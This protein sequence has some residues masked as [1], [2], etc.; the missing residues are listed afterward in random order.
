M[1]LAT[2]CL[3]ATVFCASCDSNDTHP[4]YKKTSEGMLYRFH[5]QNPNAAKPKLTDFMKLEMKCYLNDTLYYDWQEQTDDMYAQLVEPKFRGDL[6][7]AYAM[8]HVGDSASF[9]IKADS[10]ASLYYDQDPKALGLAADDYFRYE[11]KLLEIKTKEEFQ[12]GLLRV[13]E[14]MKADARASLSNYVEKENIAVEPS[15]TGVYVV[16]LEKGKGRCPEKGEKVELDFEAHLTDGTL[17]G[18]TYNSGEP[19]SFVLGDNY[20]IAGW[21]EVVS[22]MHLGD[23]VRAIIPFD[24]AYN[25]HSVG[26]IPPYAN[27]VYDIKLLKITTK[28]ELAR[29][30]EQELKKLKAE[31]ET[32]FAKFVEANQ[33]AEHTASGL[34]YAK[35]NSTE[36]ASPV[37][38]KVARIKYN[39]MQ[40]DGTPLGDTDQL[41]GHFDIEY[42][43]HRVLRGLEEG[44]GLLKV[45]ERARLV[46]PYKLAYGEKAYNGIPPCSN[47]IFDVELVEIVE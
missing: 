20:V 47:L 8:L 34:Y 37:V 38:G 41:G 19:F 40:L 27:L 4:G 33:I 29:Q 31:K 32:E 15:E 30:A 3:L 2:I 17:V 22:Q 16:N 7:S 10:I 46:I 28:E 43:K 14:K 26:N 13:V 12:D 5:R 9:Y 21:E 25:E 45:G 35:M 11:M 1:F 42:G 39:A 24:M 44:V 18:S 36:G 6:M 23:K